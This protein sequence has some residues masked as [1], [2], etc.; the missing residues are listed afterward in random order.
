MP[1]CCFSQ[2]SGMTCTCSLDPPRSSASS[3]SSKSSSSSLY[4]YS[5]ESSSQR[6]FQPKSL[7]SLLS[8]SIKNFFDT[9]T[10]TLVSE[11][12][13]SFSIAQGLPRSSHLSSSSRALAR[14]FSVSDTVPWN[15]FLAALE[16]FSPLSLSPGLRDRLRCRPSPRPSR[17]DD[18]ASFLASFCLAR[19][20]A[21]ASV[22]HTS[23][24]P[25]DMGLTVVQA[26]QDQSTGAPAITNP[27][28]SQTRR[29]TSDESANIFA[30]FVAWSR[31]M[32]SEQYLDS[33]SSEKQH[34]Q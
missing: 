33:T 3:S 8:D 12:L 5:F 14:A 20:S 32:P 1:F 21:G 19:I 23:Q 11:P 7:S 28:I 15:F 27:G 31:V 13:L 6:P 18:E 34:V 17:R 2:S 16:T 24:L 10:S 25:R 30:W 9:C 29:R 4:K 26:G 22:S